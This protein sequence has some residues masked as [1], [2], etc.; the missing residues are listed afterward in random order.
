MKRKLHVLILTVLISLMSTSLFAQVPYGLNSFPSAPATIFI[1]FDGQ[2][3]ISPYW[4]SGDPIDCLPAEL[5][6]AQMIRIFNQVAE[7]FRPFNLNITTDSSVYFAAPALQRQRIIVTPS[8]AWFGTAGGVAM[9]NS[10]RW[11]LEIPGFVFSNLLNNNV[12]NVAEAVSHESGHTLGLQHQSS[13]SST[14]TF[15][16]EY[17]PGTG[18]GEIGWAPI[19]GNSYNRNL[20]LWHNGSTLLGCNNRQDDLAIISKTGRSSN[21]FGYRTDDI[22]NTRNTATS[23][24]VSNNNYAINGFI[25][26]T[27][28]IDIFR[29]DLTQRSRLLLNS[30]PFSVAEGNTAA[31]IDIQV[32]L[33][34]SGGATLANYNPTTS[35]Q[36]AVDSTLDAGTYYIQVTNTSNNNTTNYGMLGSYIMSGTVTTASNLLPV[37][38]LVLNGKKVNQKH[39]LNWSIAADEAL[40]SFLVETSAD[41]KQFTTLQLL[42]GKES[43]FS[44]Q[45]L[46]S[47]NRFYRVKVT[48]ASQL[49]Y[50]SNI[51]S[52]QATAEGAKYQIVNHQPGNK[53]ILVNSKANFTYRLTDMGGRNIQSGR[54]NIGNNTLGANNLSAGMYLLQIIDGTETITEKILIR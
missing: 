53:N 14:C 40:E 22:G 42:N 18:T 38:S 51:V 6:N 30:L 27:S 35:V 48:T 28:D 32:S 47:G 50:Y 39:E 24:N 26:N 9:T 7:D 17:N 44:Y 15:E 52:L 21:N 23:I 16:S 8:S 4:N 34:N 36:V 3:V 41:G 19:M 31:N 29:M 37:H 33:L 12:K 49:T 54:M 25:N 46:E 20:S 1:D 11:G 13:Y 2:M 43:N 10:F 45:P 5:T